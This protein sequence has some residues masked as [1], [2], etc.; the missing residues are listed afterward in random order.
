MSNEL[1]NRVP[2]SKLYEF[3]LKGQSSEFSNEF[4][5]LL[6]YHALSA[7][8][9]KVVDFLQA[10]LDNREVKEALPPQVLS[11]YQNLLEHAEAALMFA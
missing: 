11:V 2:E 9:P 7:K 1:Q 10:V 8:A 4:N 3:A 5:R 6:V